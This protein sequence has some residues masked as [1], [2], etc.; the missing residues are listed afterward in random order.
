[1]RGTQSRRVCRGNCI[2]A[3]VLMGV[4]RRYGLLTGS[5]PWLIAR[6]GRWGRG[7]RRKDITV[8][9]YQ[10]QKDTMDQ[11]TDS[12]TG[13]YAI[14]T[15]SG[16]TFYLDMDARTFEREPGEP[17]LVLRRDRETVRLVALTSCEIGMP[18]SLVIDLHARNVFA[19]TRITMPVIIIAKVAGLSAAAAGSAS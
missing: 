17:D 4:L 9:G 8:F 15:A 6:R 7:V 3:R 12:S 2:P 10:N 13:C 19:T 11:L 5:Q 18:M 14:V 1:M 16:S